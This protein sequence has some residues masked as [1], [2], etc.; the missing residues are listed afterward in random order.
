MM[1]TARFIG[2]ISLNAFL[3]AGCATYSPLPLADGPHLASSLEELQNLS[4]EN[5]GAAKKPL[6]MSDI[7][8]LAVEYNPDLKAARNDTQIAEAQI[9]QAGIFPNPQFN[10]SYD[11]FMGGPAFA[12]AYGL[13]LAEDIKALVMRGATRDAAEYDAHKVDADLLWQEWQ[14]VGKARLLYVDLAEMTELQSVLEK[15]RRLLADRYN[16]SHQALLR[17]DV[18]LSTEAPDLAALSDMEKQLNDLD[19]QIQSKWQEMDALLGL[20]PDVRFELSPDIPILDVNRKAIEKASAELPSRPDLAA[21]KFGYESQEQKLRAAI[22]GQFPA[23][24]FGGSYNSD[25][26]RVLSGGPLVTID[27]PVFNRNQGNIAIES[28]TRQKLR[29]AYANRLNAA[30]GQLKA[31]TDDDFL[32]QGQYAKTQ[33]IAEAAQKAGLRADA[34]FKAGNIDERSYVDLM[35]V[36]FNQKQ[37]MIS[38]KQSLLEQQVAL[39]TLL[40]IGMPP[41]KLADTS[42]E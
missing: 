10:G 22:L 12:N 24:V 33:K 4:S 31:M 20:E 17:G 28:A 29:E 8:R 3:L 9:V 27:L 26:S 1:K 23:L 16:H 37:Q 5:A 19:R 2:V 39:A 18:D 30:A 15:S 11:F 41:I 25:T 21:L 42:G 32:L 35:M 14:T 7:T 13:G 38:L 6:A 34:A 40:G 36:A